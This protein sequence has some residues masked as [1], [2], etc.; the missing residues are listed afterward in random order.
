MNIV[1]IS[2]LRINTVIGV[3][4]WERDIKQT[5]V[6][7][8]E[9]STD[10]QRAA[11]EDNLVFTLDYGAIAAGI[12]AFVEASSYQLIESLAEAIADLV[13]TDFGV[14]QLKLKLGKPGAV[15]NARD[16]GVIIHRSAAAAS[17]TPSGV[18]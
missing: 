5:V 2:E 14:Q 3:Y 13:M 6:V 16:V 18:D 11:L 12:T 15:E 10:N 17:S 1:Y 8:L 9:M 7:D 4:G